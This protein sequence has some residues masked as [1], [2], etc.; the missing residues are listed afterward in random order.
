MTWL[1]WQSELRTLFTETLDALD[2]DA[3]VWPV[4]G[5]AAPLLQTGQ[6]GSANNDP[7]SFWQADLD[8]AARRLTWMIRTYKPDVV[9]TYNAFGGYGHPDHIRVHDVAIACDLV[10]LFGRSAPL[11]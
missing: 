1:T 11:L 4:N 7:R 2:L 10:D 3:L 5:K 8:E 6:P 9:T